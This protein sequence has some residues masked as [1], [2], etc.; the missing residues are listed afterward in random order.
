MKTHLIS[1]YSIFL[2]KCNF[3]SLRSNSIFAFYSPSIMDVQHAEI[4]DS[5][6]QIG[7]GGV[8]IFYC[9]TLQLLFFSYVQ[10]KSFMAPL[11]SVSEELKNVFRIEVGSIRLISL[12]RSSL[13]VHLKNW[14]VQ[15]MREEASGTPYSLTCF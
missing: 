6:E 11:K 12:L 15:I 10:G 5:A 8:S 2:E 1:W 14:R 7:G 13:L 9:H 3:G 4:K